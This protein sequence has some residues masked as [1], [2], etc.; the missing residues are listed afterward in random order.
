MSE[1]GHADALTDIQAHTR[2]HPSHFLTTRHAPPRIL[3]FPLGKTRS[4]AT[5]ADELWWEGGNAPHVVSH[6]L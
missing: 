3:P 5:V 2:S 4:E 6:V 1:D